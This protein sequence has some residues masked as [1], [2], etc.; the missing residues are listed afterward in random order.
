V[1]V[2]RSGGS[3]SGYPCPEAEGTCGRVNGVQDGY[4]A[5]SNTPSEDTDNLWIMMNHERG[6][7]QRQ[8][9]PARFIVRLC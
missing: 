9:S 6:L 2:T 4:Q 1:F 3:A 7:V 8:Q 5:G